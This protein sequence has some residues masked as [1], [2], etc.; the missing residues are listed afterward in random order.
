MHNIHVY[1]I[2]VGKYKHAINN[3]HSNL[4]RSQEFNVVLEKLKQLMKMEEL[5]VCVI[6][7]GI[8]MLMFSSFDF[9]EYLY[10]MQAVF[11]LAFV[12]L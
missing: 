8:Y 1:I 5:Y 12:L 9:H 3:A 10:Y 11:M 4:D 7:C 6:V 2:C